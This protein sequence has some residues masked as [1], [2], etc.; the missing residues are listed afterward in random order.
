MEAQSSGGC[1]K[2]DEASSVKDSDGKVVRDT[3]LS[4]GV[5]TNTYT[6]MRLH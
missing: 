5:G 3:I 6:S 1:E 4:H 2:V